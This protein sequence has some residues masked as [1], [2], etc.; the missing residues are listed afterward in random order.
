MIGKEREKQMRSAVRGLPSYLTST[1]L[2]A[3]VLSSGMTGLDGNK[4]LSQA[5]ANGVPES[6]FETLKHSGM[7]LDTWSV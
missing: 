3:L 5:R 4:I 6:T 7:N 1:R 2:C